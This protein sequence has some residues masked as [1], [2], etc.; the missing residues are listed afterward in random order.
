MVILSSSFSFLQFVKTLLH[1]DIVN[2]NTKGGFKR[3][4]LA[5]S[6]RGAKN[7]PQALTMKLSGRW[8]KQRIRLTCTVTVIVAGASGK[9][10]QS[11]WTILRVMIQSS[12]CHHA[13]CWKVSCIFLTV[14]A[15]A[16]NCNEALHE[17]SS[18]ALQG[19]NLCISS[20]M[21]CLR[22]RT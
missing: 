3:E 19:M 4:Y 1:S 12:P 8:G 14:H 18:Y 13:Q 15:S 11:G 2:S 20:T 21:F 9:G 5:C 7:V 17:K 16:L 6:F 22:H 10:Q